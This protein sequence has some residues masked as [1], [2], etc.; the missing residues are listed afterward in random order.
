MYELAGNWKKGWAIDQHTL[1]SIPLADGSFE[2][3]RTDLGEALYQLKYKNHYELIDPIARY[4]VYFLNENVWATR[5]FAGVIV[6]P[7]SKQRNRQPVQEIA[8]L[9][10]QYLNIPISLNYLTKIKV[11]EQLKSVPYEE[12][13]E[14]LAGAYQVADLRYWN[15]SVLL[16]DDL[17]CSGATLQEVTKTLYEQGKVKSVF[18]LTLTKTR[19]KK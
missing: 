18:V 4:C 2:T 10:A 13:K 5:S 15:K 16:F 17:F 14:I 3:K 8:E 6:T 19:T 11:T 1:S 12:K 7:P 9:I